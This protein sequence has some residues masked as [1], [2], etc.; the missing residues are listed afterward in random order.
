MASC[1]VSL[2]NLTRALV[3]SRSSSAA[4]LSRPLQG[5]RPG[6]Q[7]EPVGTPQGSECESR[8]QELLLPGDNA[9]GHADTE[10]TLH[11]GLPA[12]WSTRTCS[13]GQVSRCHQSPC[14]VHHSR[15]ARNQ[16]DGLVGHVVL[17]FS[18]TSHV[19]A[20]RWWHV[21]LQRP[22]S[23]S[24]GEQT[25]GGGHGGVDEPLSAPPSLLGW[26]SSTKRLH[27]TPQLALRCNKKFIRSLLFKQSKKCIL[28]VQQL[29][30]P[31]SLIGETPSLHAQA[32]SHLCC[33]CLA[34]VDF[35]QDARSFG[36][37]KFLQFLRD[38]G[39]QVSG[40]QDI[41][42]LQ[43]VLTQR[44][45]GVWTHRCIGL[46]KGGEAMFS[47]QGVFELVAV[48]LFNPLVIGPELELWLL[49]VLLE[50]LSCSLVSDH[51]YSPCLPKVAGIHGE[52]PIRSRR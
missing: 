28:M 38:I 21:G 3:V 44:P 34:T 18:K 25:S 30:V 2:R 9:R 48:V 43:L 17:S 20:A 12:W 23:S 51:R 22:E 52:L 4:S 35:P 27:T 11:P 13:S 15:T 6:W 31:P 1:L 41:H 10:G 46:L 16:L 24:R 42:G 32:L 45:G 33:S 5:R 26:C 36:A 37:M 49:R 50:A 14:T 47:R 39:R 19:S 29:E 7:Q 8:T 40:E